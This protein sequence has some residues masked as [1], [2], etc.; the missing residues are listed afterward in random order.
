MRRTFNRGW[1]G[2]AADRRRRKCE[3]EGGG[4]RA[5]RQGFL[6]RRVERREGCWIGG[7]RRQFA[8]HGQDTRQ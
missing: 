6:Q 2:L 7:I 3:D 8:C 5:W 1:A 4:E